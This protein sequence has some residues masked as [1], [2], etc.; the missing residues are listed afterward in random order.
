MLTIEEMEIMLDELSQEF[1][2]VFYEKL[3]GGIILLP[4][5]KLHPKHKRNDLFIMGEYHHNREMGRY[6]VIYYGSFIRVH[7]RLSN[8]AIKE[9]LRKT[10]RHEFRHH[11]E[12]LAGDKGLIKKD[13]EDI[14]EYLERFN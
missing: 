5:T 12:S 14:N 7:G 10:L 6:I 3:N 11:I 2:P 8:E 9:N 4:E 13:I 1:P